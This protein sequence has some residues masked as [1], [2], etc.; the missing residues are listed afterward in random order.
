MAAGLTHLNERGE[1]QIVDIG[2]KAVT[3]PP[4][5]RPG[6]ARGQARDHRRHPRRHAQEGRRPRRRPR[7]RHHGGQEDLGP[8]PALPPD[9]ADQRRRSTSSGDGDALAITATAETTG[10]TGVEMEALTAA[11]VAALTLYDMAKAID[12][13]M[14]DR[15]RRARREVRRQVRRLQAGRPMIPVDEALDRILAQASPTSAPRPC[16][17]PKRTAASSP[18]RSSPRT[19]SRPST[20]APW[21][22]TPCAPPTSSRAGR[23][24]SPAPSQAGAAL[25]RHDGARPVRPHLHRRAAADRRRRRGHAGRGT[26]Q[27]A[28]TVS[29]T[30]RP[31]RAQHPPRGMDFADGRRAAARRRRAHARRCSTSPPPPTA[32]S[33]TVARR[34]RVAILATGDELVPPGTAARPRPDRRLQR[35]RALRRSSARMPPTSSTSASSATTSRSSRTPLLRAF[36]CG[37]DVIITTGGASVGE[38]DYVQEVL[39]RPRR[40]ARLL[41]DR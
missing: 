2:D 17:S 29:F 36:D 14:R 41:E 11:S 33:S 15:R 9:R 27:T 32:P 12:R 21:T 22:A 24:A 40:R 16:R 19:A 28:T 13:G 10:Q 7:R 31:R 39:R 23:C 38:R 8:D 35:L 3:A 30:K 1:A 25:R 6:P 37:V 4:R 20:P 26:R 5:R 34:P 18:R